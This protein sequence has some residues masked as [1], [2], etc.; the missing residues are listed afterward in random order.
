MSSRS[1]AVRKKVRGGGGQPVCQVKTKGGK[2]FDLEENLVLMI[3]KFAELLPTASSKTKEMKLCPTAIELSVCPTNI[4][5]KPDAVDSK[6]TDPE[7]NESVPTMTILSRDPLVIHLE[8]TKADT[9][10]LLIRW[11]RHHVKDP[12]MDRFLTEHKSK[13]NT[14]PSWDEKFFAKVGKPAIFEL[15]HHSSAFNIY[16]LT[17]LITKTIANS[18]KGKSAEEIR[19]AFGLKNDFTPEEEEK[20]KQEGRAICRKARQ[21]LGKDGDDTDEDEWKVF[22]G[23]TEEEEAQIH[24]KLIPYFKNLGT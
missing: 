22:E 11:C 20:V 23:L 14:V 21:L 7:S 19:Q 12:E 16:Y 6:S 9:F 15:V 17:E 13:D 4:C 5:M 3:G 8:R 2:T 18:M 10:A 24:Q 1:L